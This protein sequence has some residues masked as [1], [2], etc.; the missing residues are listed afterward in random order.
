MTEYI[1]DMLGDIDEE[2][3][4][5]ALDLPQQA[6]E[7]VI[8]VDKR[9][10]RNAFFAAAAAIAAGLMVVV[11]VVFF[12]AN[13]G[14]GDITA[15]SGS[16]SDVFVPDSSYNGIVIPTE[17]TDDDRELQNLLYLI[18]DTAE[19]LNGHFFHSNR[20]ATYSVNVIFPQLKKPITFQFD[21]YYYMQS[22]SIGGRSLTDFRKRL[23]ETFTVEAV[24]E[25]MKLIA[26][27][28][29]AE[30]VQYDCDLA[31]NIVEG[32]IFD[33]DGY[34][35]ELP[36]IFELDEMLYETR[37]FDSSEQTFSG[38]W[39]TAKVVSKTD[40]EIIFTYIRDIN[41]ELV[42]ETGRMLNEDDWWKF[43]WCGGWIL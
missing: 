11:S 34:L 30:D 36:R 35:T 3:L 8:E 16:S 25:Y 23:C 14:R 27:A 6:E 19:E 31:V 38:Y 5:E 41:G 13:Y 40:D 32:G 20:S 43:S 10:D 4:E 12:R 28:E 24:G 18:D 7:V 29:K 22:F 37:S 2:L 33:E 42:Q 1:I 9:R 15:S 26:V 21:K 17:F 39:S